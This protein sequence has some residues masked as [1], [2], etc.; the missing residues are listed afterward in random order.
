MGSNVMANRRA[1]KPLRSATGVDPATRA[2]RQ[3]LVGVGAL[4]LLAWIEVDLILLLG[5]F[6]VLSS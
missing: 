2:A 4:V 1:G 3:S 6:N 5:V